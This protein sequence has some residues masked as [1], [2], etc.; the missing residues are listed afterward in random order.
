MLVKVSTITN[1]QLNWLVAKA[2]N[3]YLY[4]RCWW[5][6]KA[7]GEKHYRQTAAATYTPSTD[8]EQGGPII[9]REKIELRYHDKVVAGIWYRDGIGSDQCLFKVIGSTSLIAAM[10]CFVM[11][12][13]GEEVEVPDGLT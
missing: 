7:S 9:D 12:R 13:L 3:W 11:S 1:N 4:D 6:M 5:T 8:W 2:H 10:R